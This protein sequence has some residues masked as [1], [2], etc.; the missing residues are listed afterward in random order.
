MV[1]RSHAIGKIRK[2]S[3]WSNLTPEIQKEH[4]QKAVDNA[5]T[6]RD[7]KKQR[8]TQMWADMHGDENQANEIGEQEAELR[9]IEEK[10]GEAEED[11][12]EGESSEE[13][14]E[15]DDMSE[16]EEGE[17]DGEEWPEEARH[18]LHEDLGLLRRRQGE[19]L[20]TFLEEMEAI[21]KAREGEEIPDD[22]EFG[23][24]E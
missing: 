16:A 14:S 11:V 22:Y 1:A 5:N 17:E 9:E 23:C 15:L 21:G 7:L 8:A 3:E 2:T 6:E 24:T 10:A 13:I 20:L 18:A 12:D 4:I 19:E